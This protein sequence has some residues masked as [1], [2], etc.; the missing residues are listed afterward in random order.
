ML[1][2]EEYGILALTA[3]AGWQ[4][5][6]GQA[7]EIIGGDGHPVAL[8]VHKPFFVGLNIGRNAYSQ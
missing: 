1:M 8:G 5:V 2:Q 3:Q 6:Q 7:D 4:S